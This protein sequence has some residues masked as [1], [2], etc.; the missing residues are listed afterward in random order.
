MGSQAS[1]NPKGDLGGGSSCHGDGRVGAPSDS[2]LD[3]LVPAFQL[4]RASQLPSCGSRR[5]GGTVSAGADCAAFG[6][7]C[8]GWQLPSSAS[9]SRSLLCNASATRVGI[10]R[11]PSAS[12]TI[13]IPL[14]GR[15]L[16]WESSEPILGQ[17]RTESPW[18]TQWP[19]NCRLCQFC[20]ARGLRLA[21]S[22]MGTRCQ[23]QTIP[24]HR[25]PPGAPARPGERRLCIARPASDRGSSRRRGRL[26]RRHSLGCG[27]QY[28][29][30][31]SGMQG[32]RRPPV[33][34][35]AH[36]RTAGQ[37]CSST[38][39]FMAVSMASQFFSECSRASG[40]ELLSWESE[41]LVWSPEADNSTVTV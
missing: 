38:N 12:S 34:R 10:R 5:G 24:Y 35:C 22:P 14:V 13:L 17:Q 37:A 2:C 32:R 11:C 6:K 9:S 31:A 40:S 8:R 23:W 36:D 15:Q 41:T 27:R 28:D 25:F 33:L 7:V 39:F 18:L 16:S 20:R 26:A 3:P 4:L 29:R 1:V 30:S 19:A 21:H